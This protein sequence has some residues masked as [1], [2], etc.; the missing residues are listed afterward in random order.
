VGHPFAFTADANT[1]LP[2]ASF[3]KNPILK[4]SEENKTK[5]HSL[6][7]GVVD[8]VGLE[9]TTSSVPW[10]RAFAICATDPHFNNT[11]LDEACKPSVSV[12]SLVPIICGAK[13][14]TE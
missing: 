10:K 14:L 12:R 1:L 2:L 11:I 13:S 5:E 4:K 3:I 7:D 9:P 6:H 8:P